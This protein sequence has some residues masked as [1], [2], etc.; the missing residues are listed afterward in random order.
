MI[1]PKCH[2]DNSQDSRYC[3]GCGL[4]LSGTGIGNNFSPIPPTTTPLPNNELFAGRYILRK[5]LGRGG[6]GI[7]YEAEDTRLMRTVALKFIT[8]EGVVDEESRKRFIR[9]ARAA[10]S[11]DFPTICTIYEVDAVEGQIFISMAF[12]DGIDLQKKMAGN[13]LS[14]EESVSITIQI[15]QGL[16]EAHKKGIIHRDIKPANIMINDRNQIKIMDFGLAKSMHDQSVSKSDHII[17]TALYMSPE[18]IRGE[19]IDH[20]SDI[21]S[22]GILLYQMISG[23]L[24]FNGPQPVSVLFS[25]LKDDVPPI[26]EAPAELQRIILKALEKES[27]NRYSSASDFYK[28]LE[29]FLNRNRNSESLPLIEK[30]KPFNWF[31][32]LIPFILVMLALGFW[33]VR[34]IQNK[35]RIEFAR[36]KLLPKAEAL[37]RDFLMTRDW[38]KSIDAFE[39]ATQA[40]QIIPDEPRLIP[41]FELTSRSLSIHSK[42]EGA[43]IFYKEYSIPGENWKYLGTT[44]LENI[45]MPYAFFQWKI[46][47]EGYIPVIAVG[48]SEEKLIERTLDPIGKIPNGMVRINSYKEPEYYIPP[49]FI[50]RYEVTNRQY[51][52]FID[53]GGYTDSRYWKF[54]FEE[55]GKNIPFEEAMKRFIDVSGRPGPA[56]WISGY[57]PDGKAD[58][59]VSGISWYEAAAYAEFAGKRLP[60]LDEWNLAAGF[61]IDTNI[62]Y[63]SALIIPQSHFGGDGPTPV[64]TNQGINAFGALDMAGNVREWCFNT[65]EDGH[66]IKG[67]AW[68]DLYYMYSSDAQASSFDRSLKNGFRCLKPASNEPL[69]SYLTDPVKPV[70][71]RDY[72]KEKPVDDNAFNIYLNRFAYDPIPLD[73]KIEYKQTEERWIKEKITFQAAYGNERV[74]L[75]LFLPKNSKPPYQTVVFFPWIYTISTPDS[76]KLQ[77]MEWVDFF[78]KSG[79]AL[80]YPIYKG[81]YERNNEKIDAY[82]VAPIMNLRYRFSEYVGMLGKDMKR[83]IDYLETRNEIDKEKLAYYSFSWGSRMG[84]IM[85]AIEK[86]FKAAIMALGGLKSYSALP[87]VDPINFV[88]R[89]TLPVLMLNG[90]Y[91]LNFPLERSIQ[92]LYDLLGTPNKDKKLVLYDTDHYLPLEKC[93]R[94][95]LDW[96]DKYL[97]P[98]K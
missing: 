76:S 41:V 21:W 43:K 23:R 80:A 45:T 52:E 31:L 28:D 71:Q 62:L 42:P 98:V 69:P 13:P 29:N 40:R 36:G 44:P 85:L 11:L 9:E 94:E 27:S 97:G 72:Y 3:S 92:P 53:K 49:F 7:V 24:P 75:Y 37:S 63:F 83:V 57:Y 39:T 59:P 54:P 89:I 91:D 2:Q 30:K 84:I 19:K 87:E 66:L 1:C 95:S 74:I 20:R 77:Q 25:I 15:A 16:E 58:L 60:T 32:I 61:F 33:G 22:L 34:Y 88:S 10:A 68:S 6:M 79:R 81:T 48:S 78:I 47:K 65:T 55:D 4:L 26:P 46:E 73:P 14:I 64:G 12:I 93:I 17:G 35:N 18:Q 51:K 90:K 96:L 67:G 5:M 82:L 38:K 8:P 70:V 86:R 56:S 50:D